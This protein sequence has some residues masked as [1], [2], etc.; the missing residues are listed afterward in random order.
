MR[1]WRSDFLASDVGGIREA[2]LVPGVRLMSPT[3]NGVPVSDVLPTK[4]V[5]V[6]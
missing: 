1:H 3:P 4:L 6:F 2:D 5:A